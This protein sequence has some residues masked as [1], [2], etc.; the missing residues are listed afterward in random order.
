MYTTNHR[1]YIIDPIEG[2][3]ESIYQPSHSICEKG[4]AGDNLHTH[5]C[6]AGGLLQ[7][8]ALGATAGAAG[9]PWEPELL[10]S[11]PHSELWLVL[12]RTSW[13]GIY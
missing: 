12:E 11:T 13:V 9:H 10:H 2:K 8:R 3:Q 4:E 6:P 1:V 5:A 7:Q